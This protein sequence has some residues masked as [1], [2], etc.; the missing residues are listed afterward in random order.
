[1]AGGGGG[2]WKVA[3]ADFVTAMM[4]FF[5]VMWLVSQDQKIKESIAHYFQGP[6]GIDLLGEKSRRSQAGG[7]FYN[8]VMGPVPGYT[9]RTAG[10]SIGTSPE[11][12]DANSDTMAVAE[13]VLEDK[14]ISP[15]WLNRAQELY[16]KARREHPD[17]RD[18]SYFESIV[19]PQLIWELHQ[20]ISQPVVDEMKGLHRELLLNSLSKIDWG[21][22]ADECLLRVKQDNR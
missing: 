14:E 20:Q 16:D 5:L 17:Q 1:M 11:P 7:L 9:D 10:R 15:H 2:A 19:R 21:A 4:A 22:I 6:V 12:P 13:W 18:H 8:E 3:Y